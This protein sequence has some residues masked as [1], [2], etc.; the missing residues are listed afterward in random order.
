MEMPKIGEKAMQHHHHHGN[1]FHGKFEE[2]NHLK[3]G[4]GERIDYDDE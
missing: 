3:L 2:H 4:G 1:E